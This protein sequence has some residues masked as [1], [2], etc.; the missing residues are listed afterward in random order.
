MVYYVRLEKRIIGLIGLIGNLWSLL[1]FVGVFCVKGMR[2]AIIVIA[3][4]LLGFEVKQ[5]RI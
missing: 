5:R 2:R 1:G 4:K 3:I